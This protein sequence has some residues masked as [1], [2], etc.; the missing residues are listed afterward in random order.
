MPRVQSAPSASSGGSVTRHDLSGEAIR[1][2]RLVLELLAEAEPEVMGLVALMLLQESR[3][4]ARSS[5][6]GELVLLEHQDRSLWNREQIAEGAA[7]VRRALLSRRYGPYSLQAAIA[8]CHA[9][10]R[11]AAGG[12]DLTF[13]VGAV[14]GN[15]DGFDLLEYFG[16]DWRHARSL[17]S[18]VESQ[19]SWSR[20]RLDFR[21]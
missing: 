11:Q 12:G 4:Q 19:G 18:R 14:A 3:R 17:G 5:A 8:A 2:G 10:A 15:D 1:L 13:A 21:H 6:T 16:G 7:L 9:R 20:V